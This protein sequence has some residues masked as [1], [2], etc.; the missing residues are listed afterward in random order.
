MVA[1]V[2][3]ATVNCQAE[4]IN[5][6]T[7]RR[8]WVEREAANLNL[9]VAWQQ[10]FTFHKQP[11]M[12]DPDFAAR[13]AASP[14]YLP[15]QMASELR[16]QDHQY[17]IRITRHDAG[18]FEM[19]LT[20]RN[21][22]DG[23]CSYDLSEFH[24]DDPTGILSD[25]SDRFERFDSN[26]AAVFLTYRPLDRTYS[27]IDLNQ[28]TAV[29]SGVRMNG[30]RCHLLIDGQPDRSQK[31]LWLREDSFL[32]VRYTL[33]SPDQL[34]F[35]LNFTYSDHLDRVPDLSGWESTFY[36]SGGT[37][38][39]MIQAT[40]TR[41][42]RPA[43]IPDSEFQIS[44]PPGTLVID[45]IAGTEYRLPGGTHRTV[46]SGASTTRLIFVNAG[47]IALITIVLVLRR[48]SRQSASRSE[49]EQA[50]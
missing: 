1:T 14:D 9:L 42:E 3:S 45:E 31:Q 41:L 21:S 29:H 8:A 7:I 10:K 46:A 23:S 2:V 12:A 27:P 39:E 6:D 49:G 33:S 26:N 16:L 48:M 15:M 38:D 47:V 34:I 44:W 37:P 32:P 5:V 30:E 4:S 11:Y 36:T 19:P 20:S 28:V 13:H 24:S 17:D 22:F 40:V 25:R 35:E 50:L 43:K 18:Q